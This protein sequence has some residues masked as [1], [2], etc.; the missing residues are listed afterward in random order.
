MA[1]LKTFADPTTQDDY[2]TSWSGPDSARVFHYYRKIVVTQK[3]LQCHGDLQT[4]DLDLWR[5]VKDIYPWDKASGYK[6]GDLR[7]M[8]VATAIWP[9]SE[10]MARLLADGISITKFTAPDTTATDTSTGDS[11]DDLPASNL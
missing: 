11:S 7:G 3:C 5:R 10:E 4:V 8:F 1:I 6:V 2:L 9:D